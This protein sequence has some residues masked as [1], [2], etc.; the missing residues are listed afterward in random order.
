VGRLAGSGREAERPEARDGERL[1][2]TLRAAVEYDGSR[3]CGFQF[4][5]EV[6]TVAG[7]LEAA[8]SRI[9]GEPVK[10]TGAGRTDTGVHASGQVISFTTSRSFPFERM[11]IALN[12]NL[13]DDVSVRDLEPVDARFSA[14]FSAVARRYVY[15]ILNRRDRSA[16]LTRRAYHV[17]RNLDTEAMAAAAAHF[18]GERDFRSFCSTLPEGG[19]TLRNVH[20]LSV[21]H[22][23]DTIRVTISADGFLHRMVRTIVGTLVECGSGKRD[24]D[25]IPAIL[26][27]RDRRLAGLTAPAHGLYLAGVTYNDGYDSFQEPFP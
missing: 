11:A 16:L 23:R 10:I 2:T 27:A 6:R 14:R 22:Y 13:A 12:A 4:Q 1:T 19:V 17:Y 24:P 9:L 26:A 7:D 20:G 3:F 25:A 21:E 5:P 8:I 18:I 15:I